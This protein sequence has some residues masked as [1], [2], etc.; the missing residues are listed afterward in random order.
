MEQQT[1]PDFNE[2][3]QQIALLETAAKKFMTKD[4]ISRYGTLKVAH[5][6]TA[7]K[8]IAMI[9]QAAQ[10]GQLSMP[11]DDVQFKELLLELQHTQGKKQFN[12][13]ISRK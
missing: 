1:Q 6:E 12:L 9:A 3:M 2:L 10:L 4:A 5:P 13:K 8:A 11:I 7:I